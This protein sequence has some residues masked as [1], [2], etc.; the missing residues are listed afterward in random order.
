[1]DTARS[2]TTID[3][4]LFAAL[5]MGVLVLFIRLKQKSE[6]ITQK[7]LVLLC[8]AV[9]LSAVT[10]I[11]TFIAT[12]EMGAFGRIF[13][14]I[15]N[16]VFWTILPAV[17]T[18]WA[19]YIDVNIHQSLSRLR[20]RAYYIFPML[21]NFVAVLVNPFTGF[22]FS[23]DEANRYF[24]GPGAYVCT[25][26]GWLM[27]FW[28][29][30]M[31]I[32]SRRN[33]H[34][35][36][37]R[38]IILFSFFPLP[39]NLLQLAFVG[40]TLV[41]PSIALS[42]LIVYLFLEL[43]HE[44][45][46]YMTGLLNR[47]QIDDCIVYRI[48]DYQRMGNFSL[49]LLDLDKFKAINDSYGHPEGD[50]VLKTMGK[51]L[52]RCTKKTD[53]VGRFGGDEFVIVVDSG[54]KKTLEHIIQRI[55]EQLNKENQSWDKPYSVSFSYGYAIYDP[56]VHTEM[57][58]LFEEADKKMYAAKNTRSAGSLYCGIRQ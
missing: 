53:R 47:Q 6:S 33:V 28:A 42:L 23:I 48:N 41:I 1:M 37:T 7:Y 2:L 34:F 24:R 50:G 45:R 46:D 52:Q 15:S 51:I 22:V 16:S 14:Y 40:T 58:H 20:K 55:E 27:M 49:I 9:L 26:V 13:A 12:P 39:A 19:C 38:L 17:S 35:R 5:L 10:D 44:T 29:L 32:R 56:A 18:A 4:D 31:A 54:E 36:N 43:Q 25:A 57:K 8:L 11:L 3:A 21:I 30:A